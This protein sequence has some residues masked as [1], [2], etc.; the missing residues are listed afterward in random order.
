MKSEKS[1][2]EERD[3]GRD[4]QHRN[5]HGV[6]GGLGEKLREEEPGQER[7]R[8]YR[9]QDV[10]LRD[11]GEARQERYAPLV[12]AAEECHGGDRYRRHYDSDQDEWEKR[13]GGVPPC[14]GEALEERREAL[15]LLE[16]CARGESHREHP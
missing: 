14:V 1:E 10:A 12:E 3:E 2:D 13:S 11:L 9:D 6:P 7:D 8:G 16:S 4:Q 15:Q 5:S